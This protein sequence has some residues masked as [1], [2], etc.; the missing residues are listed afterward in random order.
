LYSDLSGPQ[1]G[2]RSNRTTFDPKNSAFEPGENGVFTRVG[3]YVQRGSTICF[4][5]VLLLVLLVLVE[6]LVRSS[7]KAVLRQST[8]QDLATS[9]D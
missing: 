1:I 4:V 8:L 7:Q 6:T 9:L 5:V 3:T 2:L